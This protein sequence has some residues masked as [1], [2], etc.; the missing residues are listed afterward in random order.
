MNK[1]ELNKWKRF[2]IKEQ[3]LN[4]KEYDFKIPSFINVLPL[5]SKLFGTK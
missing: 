4:H 2:K 3:K 5:L 1:Y